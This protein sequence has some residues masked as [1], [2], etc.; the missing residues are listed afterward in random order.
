M[1]VD[2]RDAWVRAYLEDVFNGHNLQSLDK[3]MTETLISH[4]LGDRNLQGREAWREAMAKFFDA[5][6]DAA[7]TLN[8]LFFGNDKGVWRGTWHATQSKEWEGIAPTGRNAKW[9]VV[10]IGR[11]EGKK[12]A[13]DWVEYGRYNLFQQLGAL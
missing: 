3:Y 2:Q 8:D 4:W 5:F 12:L 6:P 1:P 10:I 13:E 11:F 9:T 7:Y